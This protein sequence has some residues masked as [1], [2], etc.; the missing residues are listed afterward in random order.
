MVCYTGDHQWTHLLGQALIESPLFW[1][2]VGL[3]TCFNQQH[4]VV[5]VCWFQSLGCSLADSVSYNFGSPKLAQNESGS[6]AAQDLQTE[7][8][9]K[10]P[11]GLKLSHPARSPTNQPGE[12]SHAA[13]VSKNSGR[14]A[15]LSK[16]HEQWES[17]QSFMFRD[18]KILC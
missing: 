16:G 4:T 5:A 8:G 14:D 15:Q 12:R 10:T 6:A 13:T 3:V 1:I 17:Q 18:Y 7:R 11:W 9:P 2:R